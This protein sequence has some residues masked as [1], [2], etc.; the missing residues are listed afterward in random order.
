MGVVDYGWTGH[1]IFG[2]LLGGLG[3]VSAMDEQGACF[4]VGFAVGLL[5]LDWIGLDSLAY[6]YLPAP[7][8][9]HAG[10]YLTSSYLLTSLPLASL[11]LSLHLRIATPPPLTLLLPPNW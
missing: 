1:G 3:G 5:G 4:V 10:N 2:H 6:H 7:L 8:L 9:P 11:A